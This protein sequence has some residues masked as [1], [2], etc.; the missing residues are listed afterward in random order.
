MKKSTNFNLF[1]LLLF[2]YYLSAQNCFIPEAS[3]IVKMNNT[4]YIV[5]D[6]TTGKYYTYSLK[7]LNLSSQLLLN[8]CSR[9]DSVDLKFGKI[10]MDLEGIATLGSNIIVVSERNRSL[11]C[12]DSIL[13]TYP[14]PFT[15]FANRG[16]EGLA[17][18]ANDKKSEQYEVAALWEG[19]YP[20]KN[21]LSIGLE[22]YDFNK[23]MS[24][25]LILNTIK[26]NV[27]DKSSRIIKLK[28]NKINKMIDKKSKDF[29]EPFANRFRAPD[30]VWY[31][32]GFIVL[33]SSERS[34]PEE[35]VNKY[36]Y[37]LLQRFDMYG[38]PIG[39]PLMLNDIL[40]DESRYNWEGLTWN[41]QDNSLILIHDSKKNTTIRIV[42]IPNSWK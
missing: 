39:E 14:E 12:V 24:P 1:L 2:P 21:D 5:S 17:I 32:N 30:L 18:K 25:F 26:S 28:M 11:I 34:I 41:K 8:D 3:G 19:G 36:K 33:L 31:K 16:I 37:K 29:I 35:P 10:K 9:L 40:G 13:K 42:K 20:I 7:G 23:S 22:Y 27:I 4:L 15:E 6:D 38:D